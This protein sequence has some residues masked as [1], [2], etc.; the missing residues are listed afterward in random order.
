MLK[1]PADEVVTLELVLR[2]PGGPVVIGSG[3]SHLAMQVDELS[4]MIE[5]VTKAGLSAGQVQRLGG[6]DGPQ[7]S[8]L[9]DPDGYRIELVQWPPGHDMRAQ[10]G[11]SDARRAATSSITPS[12]PSVYARFVASGERPISSSSAADGQPPSGL[13][14]CSTEPAEAL[15]PFQ[16]PD[17]L[18][19]YTN[20]YMVQDRIGD[21]WERCL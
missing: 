19:C 17:L 3:F 12:R 14:R 9:R 8:W 4:G 16:P 7:T 15:N 2:P 5:A 6:L 20:Y 13:S 21:P 18:N 1:F 10:V 11:S